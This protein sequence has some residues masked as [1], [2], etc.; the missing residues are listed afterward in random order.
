MSY[1]HETPIIN[2]RFNEVSVYRGLLIV[3]TQKDDRIFPVL[4]EL[5]TKYKR[6]L[7]SV[8]YHKGVL[9]LLWKSLPKDPPKDVDLEGD[10]WSIQ[11]EVHPYPE[12]PI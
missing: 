1:L 3:W 5:L 10:C 6:K 2:V 8:H 4:D 12:W 7:I 9:D 11:N